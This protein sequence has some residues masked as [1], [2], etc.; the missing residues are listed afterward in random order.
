MWHFI[1]IIWVG[2]PE[3]K[4]H[5]VIVSRICRNVFCF[6]FL[7]VCLHPMVSF[8]THLFLFLRENNSSHHF[9]PSERE[10]YLVAMSLFLSNMCHCLRL[11]FNPVR[12]H[13]TYSS[14]NGKSLQCLWVQGYG[15]F[16]N[17]PICVVSG[18]VK[19]TLIG[20][21]HNVSNVLRPFLWGLNQT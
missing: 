15:Y 4:V 14:P 17:L 5:V 21:I 16:L 11:K 3:M 6:L 13:L 19:Q 2:L 7:E 20:L 12:D 1:K 9:S 8:N 18:M 10:D